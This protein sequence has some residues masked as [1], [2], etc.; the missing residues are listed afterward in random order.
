MQ[1]R[2]NT[3][4][5]DQELLFMSIT[6]PSVFASIVDR[7]QGPFIKKAI[8]ILGNEEDAQDVVQEAFVKIYLNADKFERRAGATL[9]SWAYKILLNTC[10]S[11]YKKHKREKGNAH[12]DESIFA[13]VEEAE[14]ESQLERFLAVLSKIPESTSRLLHLLIVEGKS[15]EEVGKLEGVTDSAL[16]VRVHRAKQAF[17]KTLIQNPNL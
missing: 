6:D 14:E 1:A 12:F 7:Y 10:F 2:E 5:S 15:Y 4:Q 16:R 3:A 8:T 17:K 13:G 9:S 11:H